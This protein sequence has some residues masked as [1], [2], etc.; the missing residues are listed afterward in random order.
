MLQLSLP[1][2][3]SPVAPAAPD[4]APSAVVMVTGGLGNAVSLQL[5][6]APAAFGAV[7]GEVTQACLLQ[8]LH[9]KHVA[10][11]GLS[12]VPNSV[13]DVAHLQQAMSMHASGSLGDAD[14]DADKDLGP[15]VDRELSCWSWAVQGEC[16][17]NPEYMQRAC[18]RAC[19]L[20]DT[21]AW[22]AVARELLYGPRDEGGQTEGQLSA[23][24]GAEAQEAA[25]GEGQAIHGSPQPFLTAGSNGEGDSSSC[26]TQEEQA[27][28]AE[29]SGMD[30]AGAQ[31]EATPAGAAAA[32]AG[33]AEPDPGA[34]AEQQASTLETRAAQALDDSQDTVPAAALPSFPAL[35]PRL[36]ST[37]ALC[38]PALLA[39][40]FELYPET[41][42]ESTAAGAS[43]CSW[44]EGADQCLPDEESLWSD[45]QYKLVPPHAMGPCKD[46]M[47]PWGPLVLVSPVQGCGPLSNA[48]EL[49]GAIAVVMRGNCS[50][51]AKTLAAQDA[52][53]VGVVVVNNARDAGGTIVMS[54][55]SGGAVPQIP[56][57]LVSHA[58]GRLLQQAL[59]RQAGSP[60]R[61]VAGLALLPPGSGPRRMAEAG[62]G[63]GAER[64]G[65]GERAGR[66]GLESGRDV[67]TAESGQSGEGVNTA[68][69]TG[70]AD[71]RQGSSDGTSDSGSSAS[72][73]AS[74]QQGRQSQEDRG[75]CRA[76]AASERRSQ[77]TP[78]SGTG[79]QQ[80]QPQIDMLVPPS[81]HP[82]LQAQMLQYNL[83]SDLNQVFRSL[84][85]D[86]RATS[87]LMSLAQEVLNKQPVNAA[88]SAGASSG[89]TPGKA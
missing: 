30:T 13:I 84:L 10:W 50:F 44:P 66:E 35:P 82:F 39:D 87:L 89:G 45:E 51:V 2:P 53:A 19:Q 14:A 31:A 7:L 58:S 79:V 46:L 48:D 86:G 68:D 81:T 80:Q 28:V 72:S 56:A 55:V 73:S 61:L 47:Y 54:D 34:V 74:A 9:A 52:G 8:Q 85:Q 18:P 12:S 63:A 65:A 67:R 78:A 6:A 75:Q 76:D 42:F 27:E 20:C 11:E 1:P 17:A 29:A 43:A 38:Q 4:G 40:S 36:A 41:A 49:H 64:A 33:A 15:C 60:R 32:G 62:S 77:G 69:T 83:G 57:V 88:T 70:I 16:T 25:S 71:S 5:S 59:R 23:A 3:G 24:A 26:A 22:R 21:A 37:P